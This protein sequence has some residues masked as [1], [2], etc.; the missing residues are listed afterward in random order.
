[1]LGIISRLLKKNKKSWQFGFCGENVII[2]DDCD[3][4]ST[5]KISIEDNVFIGEKTCIFA[6]GGVTVKRGAII[7]DRVDIRTAN[8]YYDGPDLNYLPFDEKVIVKPVVIGENSWI[9]S[10]VLILPGVTIGEG[11]VVAAGAVV[12]K[13]VPDFAVVGGNPAKI[14][15][16]RD[17]DKYLQLKEKDAIFVKGYHDI[18]REIVKK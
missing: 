11:A 4:G 16:Y 8:H 1:M 18:P 12:T 3:F 14:I 15:K 17:K 10:H 9:A 2:S 6:V 7:A 13:D 5:E